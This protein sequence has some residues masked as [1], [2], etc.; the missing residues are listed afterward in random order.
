VTAAPMH[1]ALL[2]LNAG[3]SSIKLTVF[4][5]ALNQRLTG[6]ADAIGGASTLRIGDTKLAI[7]MPDHA[8][9]LRTIILGLAEAGITLDRLSAVGHRVVHGG[10]N[11]T[12]PHRITPAI[13]A[14][15]AACIPLAPLHNPHNLKAIDSITQLAPGLPQFA[16]FDTGFHATNPSLA[17]HYALPP[18]YAERGIRRYG[19]H[20]LSYSALTRNLP[21]MT[22]SPLPERLLACHLGNG[23]S[24]C[25]IRGGKSVATTMGYSPL[26]GLTMGTRAGSID[27]NAVL[28]LA[29]EQGI[30]ATRKLLNHGAGLLGL[31]GLSSDMRRLSQDSGERSHFAVAHFCYWAARHAGSMVAAMG[32]CDA[33]AFTGGIGENSPDV[34]A[35]ILGHLRWLGVDPDDNGDRPDR[36]RSAS[37]VGRVAVWV[38]PADEERE[39]ARDVLTLLSKG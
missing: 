20:G 7:D 15:I 18:E 24:L 33:I 26:E 17:T 1:D 12:D 16:S 37:G 13:R 23:A 2:V 32:G 30:E 10:A 22:G 8:A 5:M 9:A 39:I 31:S 6:V 34:R 28:R 38:V 14:A 19:F 21:E 11:L 3:S 36:P 29:E 27:A 35:G 25:A 4:D